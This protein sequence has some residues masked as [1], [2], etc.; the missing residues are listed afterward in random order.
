MAGASHETERHTV[1]VSSD[2]SRDTAILAALPQQHE[3]V[4]CRHHTMSWD[5]TVPA[6]LFAPE[7]PCSSPQLC[8]A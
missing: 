2:S 5:R 8:T 6:S 7:R 4:T 1:A 3:L